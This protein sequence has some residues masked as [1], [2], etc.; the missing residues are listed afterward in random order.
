[1]KSS[2]IKTTLREIKNSFGRWIAILAIVALGV[3]FYAGLTVTT[4]AMVRTGGDYF[5][6]KELFDL[7]LLSTLG[8]EQDALSAFEDR[9]GVEAVEGAVFT[10]FLAVDENGESRVLT[11]QTILE[12]QN[13]ITLEEGRM[14]E[15]AGECVVDAAVVDLPVGSIIRIS[16]ENEEETYDLF[17]CE[18]YTIVGKVNSVYYAQYERGSSSLGNGKVSGF[19]YLLPQGFEREYY[20]EIF[21]RFEQDY[22]VYSEEYEKAVEEWKQWAEPLTQK[23]A[24]QRYD[25][26]LA[27]ANEKIADAEKELA[28]KTAEAKEELADAQKTIDE[29]EAELADAL[30]KIE[31]GEKELADARSELSAKKKELQDSAQQLADGRSQVEAG[32]AQIADAKAQLEAGIIAMNASDQAESSAAL[33]MQL[34]AFKQQEAGLQAQLAQIQ[35]G[36]KQLAD[37]R[38]QIANAEKTIASGEEELEENRQKLADAQKDLEEGKQEYE[39]G[40]KELE[41]ETLK[42]Q[43]KIEDA[44]EEIAD[45][46]EPDTYVLGR[47]TNIGYVCFENDSGIVGGIAKVFPIFFFLVAALVCIT[48]MNRMVEEQRTQIGVLKALGYGEGKIMGKYLFYSGSAAVIGGIIGFAAGSVVFPTVIWEAYRIMY[49]LG[50]FKLMFDWRLAV[51]SLVVALL[52]SMGT[53]WLTCRM[54]LNQ[55][56]A[57]LIRPKAPKN[58]KR[59]LL[60][61]V[62]FIWKRLSFLV[63]VSIRNVLRYKKRFF[64]MV[65]GIGGCTALLVTGFGVKDSIVDVAVQQ[66]EEIQMYE[67]SLTLKDAFSEKTQSVADT[68]LENGAKAYTI[69]SEKSMDISGPEATKSV[70]VVIPKNPEEMGEYINLHT[71]D[72]IPIAWPEKGEAVLNRELAEKCGIKVGDTVSLRNDDGDKLKVT[73]VGLNRNFVYDYVYVSPD[74]WQADNGGEPEYKSI[75]MLT[76]KDTDVR[77]FSEELLSLEEVSAVT[78]NRDFMDRITN[79]MSSLDYIVLLIILCAGALAFIVIYNLTNINITERIREIATIKV[80]GFKSG[81]TA[82]YVFRENIVLTAIGALVGEGL[83]VWLH[84]FVM[85]KIKVDMVS[86]DVRI[87]P[88]SYVKSFL[89]TFVFMIVVDIFMYIKLEKIDMAESLKSIE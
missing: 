22:E 74:T 49:N 86:F 79:M 89:L 14:P 67:M 15:N 44:K 62:P 13:R 84:W 26:I 2:M 68:V 5:N 34:E 19:V 33:Q 46:E 21:I 29:G 45:I 32:L 1:M 10:D 60:E 48:T 57:E 53:T 36:E 63:K 7:R 40:E 8:F 9:D 17:S 28:D 87:L 37:G 66:Y 80:L 73:V 55:V 85:S 25:A 47:D 4:P 11:A 59:I 16:K 18:E 6:E 76:R 27:E 23:A 50:K 12:T 3:G 24:A 61:Y 38:R 31:D 65:I 75:Y 51:I 78:V 56:A 71:D 83:G 42:A 41:E 39:D 35:E 88:A 54:E 70:N 64:M 69:V 30:V 82:S 52:C 58:G 77:A 20:T 72:L 43:K 81:E